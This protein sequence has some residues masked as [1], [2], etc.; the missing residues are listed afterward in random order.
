MKSNCHEDLTKPRQL[1][2]EF[3]SIISDPHW[4]EMAGPLYPILVGHQAQ[5]AAGRVQSGTEWLSADK[6]D[7]E[8]TNSW[9]LS[10][11]FIFLLGGK[12]FLE[13]DLF[14]ASL[15][16]PLSIPCTFPSQFLPAPVPEVLEEYC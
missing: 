13:G 1:G 12:S 11:D 9:R 15:C 6:A 10:V 4:V 3:W 7:P 8:R 5:V 2:R 16:L 14:G